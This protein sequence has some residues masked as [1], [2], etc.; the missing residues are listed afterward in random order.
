[1]STYIFNSFGSILRSMIAGSYGESIFSF[2]RKAKLFQ[3]GFA[4]APAVNEASCCPTSSPVF[5]VGSVPDVGRSDGS[6]APSHCFHLH[7][8]HNVMWSTF[9]YA[10]LPSVYLLW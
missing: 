3:S 4:S 5:G 2:V 9:S 8:L 7:F 1:M 10:Y 6:A